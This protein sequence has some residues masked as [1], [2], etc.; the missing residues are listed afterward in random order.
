MAEDCI[1]IAEVE[2]LNPIPPWIFSGFLFT[3]AVVALIYNCND[4]LSFS[5]SSGSSY[6]WFSHIHYSVS[7]V[8]VKRATETCNF[9]AASYVVHFTTHIQTRLATNQVVASFESTDFWLVK[10]TLESRHTR[11][12][13]HLLQN[14]TSGNSEQGQIQDF[15]KEEVVMNNWITAQM[16]AVR[17]ETSLECFSISTN[18]S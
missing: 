10:I 7:K 6:I 15:F 2:G 17:G 5:S 3:T 8:T 13:H 1:A 9:S 14:K 12:F 4:L 11:D 16:T 18:R